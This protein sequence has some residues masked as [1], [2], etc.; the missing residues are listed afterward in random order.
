[1][2]KSPVSTCGVY[3][4]LCFPRS[5]RAISVARRPSTLSEASTTYHPRL[6]V[7][8]FAETVF[9]IKVLHGEKNRGANSTGCPSHLQPPS[10]P[11]PPLN[12]A[13]KKSV[14]GVATLNSPKEDGGIVD[15]PVQSRNL[16]LTAIQLLKHLIQYVGE[17]LLTNKVKK[18]NSE[19][20]YI[21]TGIYYL[22]QWVT[23]GIAA[24]Q[25]T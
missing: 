2:M 4:G 12:A 22:K 13:Q 7:S 17:L 10:A 6:T 20:N 23:T 1:M 16:G 25:A 18:S 21:F 8:G 14:A 9:T 19:T 5:R 11:L 3:S 15:V 24:S